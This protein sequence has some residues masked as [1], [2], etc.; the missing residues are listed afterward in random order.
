MFFISA[1][2]IGFLIKPMNILLILMVGVFSFGRLSN[3]AR[4]TRQ[5]LMKRLHRLSVVLLMIW[6]GNLIIPIVPY[7]TINAL[8]SRFP[9]PEIDTLNP[10]IIV[11]LGGWQG[12]TSTMRDVTSPPI[13]GSGDR[14]ITGL[15]LARNFPDA[16]VTLPGGLR[17]FGHSGSGSYSEA[18]I[19]QAVIDGMMLDED[20]FIIEGLSRNTS[21]NAVF[22]KNLLKDR[23]Q[24]IDGQIVLITSAWHM[25]RAMG[26]FRSAGLNPIAY[27]TDYITSAH[28]L[29]FTDIVLNGIALTH[30]ALSE[31]IGLAAYRLTG[32][33]DRLFPGP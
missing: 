28:G 7:L 4:R 18:D 3:R 5:K 24:R 22:L 29:S 17:Q 2:I 20:R 33:I 13:S 27:P 31:V 32:R 30:T 25:P 14:L 15:I 9:K 1:K 11:I 16:L 26:S 19:S 12:A 21:E 10:D 8:E 23:R 6:I